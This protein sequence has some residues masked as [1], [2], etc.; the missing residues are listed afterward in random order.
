MTRPSLLHRSCLSGF[1]IAALAMGITSCGTL[2]GLASSLG[3]SAS[4]SPLPQPS[5]EAEQVAAV[6][7][8][9]QLQRDALLEHYVRH[10][11]SLAL[12]LQ[13]APLYNHPP[14]RTVNGVYHPKERAVREV[15]TREIAALGIILPLDTI[16]G[17]YGDTII[18]DAHG[19]PPAP[20]K[21]GD[22]SH[23]SRRDQIVAQFSAP[24]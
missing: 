17:A 16:I 21:F 7:S 4:P 8:A 20:P 1:R 6:P 11:D 15:D 13:N 18:R 9:C 10:L 5:T 23:P 3:P 24:C 12:M 2:Q 19:R 14:G 22:K